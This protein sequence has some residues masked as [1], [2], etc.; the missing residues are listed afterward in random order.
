M[1]RLHFRIHAAQT[2]LRKALQKSNSKSRLAKVPTDFPGDFVGLGSDGD[3]SNC[4]A[5]GDDVDVMMP[6]SKRGD[7][8]PAI[9][10]EVDVLRIVQGR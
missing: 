5:Q 10:S 9:Q 7:F 6:L 3:I 2:E 4:F 8:D 1:S